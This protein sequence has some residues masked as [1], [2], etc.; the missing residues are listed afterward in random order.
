[1]VFRSTEGSWEVGVVV[2]DRAQVER[3]ESEP[4]SD[5]G[6]SVVRPGGHAAA[7]RHRLR[8]TETNWD[9]FRLFFSVARTGSVNRAARE[10]GMSQPTLSRRLKELE[11]YMGAPLFF[12]ASS[13]VKLT[14]EG[15]EL[16]RSAD[17]MV[18]S[19]ESFHRDLSLRVGNRSSA[20]KI[21]ATDGLT[22]HW[23][24]PRVKKLR[25]TNSQ[26]RLEINSTVQQLNV[27]ASGLDF[28]IRMGHPGDNELIGRRVGTVLFGLFASEGYL[29]EHGSPQTVSELID[30]DIIDSAADFGGFHGERTG[31]M[32]LLTAFK[33]AGDAR[34]A[35]RLMPVANH[36]T[37]AAEGLGLAFLAV[38]FASAEGLVRV[39]P[40]ESCSLDLWLLRRRETDLRKMTKQ[41]R[42]FLEAE[43]AGSKSWFAGE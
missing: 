16:R 1:L 37:A 23:L 39:L 42:R 35:L 2:E 14:E 43:F 7:V 4:Y 13:G 41:V 19:F 38:P 29:A 18:R 6:A 25:A 21:S 28:V 15:E 9:L 20:V 10:L 12:R 36:F 5:V 30:H 27:A 40:N 31:Q 11:R 8:L 26:I 3:E 24:F 22:R 33:A 32:S 34:G 17:E